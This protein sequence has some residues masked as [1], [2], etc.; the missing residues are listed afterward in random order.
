MGIST[1]LALQGWRHGACHQC[2][3]ITIK[4]INE[5][6]N[7]GSGEANM[8]SQSLTNFGSI[9]LLPGYDIH[10]MKPANT[11]GIAAFNRYIAVA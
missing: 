2:L 5:L 7:R 9:P 10:P 3:L 4:R 11:P 6:A 1:P 8:N